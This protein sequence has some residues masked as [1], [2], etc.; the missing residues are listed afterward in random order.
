ME[1]AALRA[2]FLRVLRCT[3]ANHFTDCSTLII[4]IIIR[5]WAVGQIVADFP[6]NPKENKYFIS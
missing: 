4:I 2:D 5:G 1:K 6:S 3:L